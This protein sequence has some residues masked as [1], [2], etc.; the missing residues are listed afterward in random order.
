MNEKQVAQLSIA[1]PLL[2][3][4]TSQQGSRNQPSYQRIEKDWEIYPEYSGDKIVAWVAVNDSLGMEFI[5]SEDYGWIYNVE[6]DGKYRVAGES[7]PGFKLR[8]APTSKE[9]M[10]K[11]IQDFYHLNG[12]K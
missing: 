12:I 6:K 5:Y 1:I 8:P 3:L 9:E 7:I 4:V 11:A 2:I 10:I